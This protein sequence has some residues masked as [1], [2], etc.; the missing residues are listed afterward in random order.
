MLRCGTCKPIS[1]NITGM[2]NNANVLFRTK[3]VDGVS[4]VTRTLGGAGSSSSRHRYTRSSSERTTHLQVLHTGLTRTVR[5][6]RYTRRNWDRR[7]REREGELVRLLIRSK[8]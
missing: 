3:F 7:V 1:H 5:R 2:F 4:T 6:N 8:L